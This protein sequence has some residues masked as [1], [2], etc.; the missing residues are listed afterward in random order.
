[1]SKQQKVKAHAADCLE[2]YQQKNQIMIICYK[3]SKRA[4]KYNP[5]H[6]H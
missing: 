1:M 3:F 4:N 2:K 6:A 5:I